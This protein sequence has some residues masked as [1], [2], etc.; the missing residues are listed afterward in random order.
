MICVLAGCNTGDGSQREKMQAV[1]TEMMH[2]HE[3]DTTAELAL[4]G[5]VKWKVDMVTDENIKALQV[6]ADAFSKRTNTVPDDFHTVADELQ[7][8]LNK[9][10]K[11][12]RMK[13]ADHD[14]L[15]HWLEPILMEVKDLKAIMHIGDGNK[16]FEKVHRQLKVYNHYFE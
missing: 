9:V 6:I 14:A 3:G 15:H 2:R 12:C 11:E 1:E 7:S 8:G 5:E 13:G 4:N 16:S 10:M